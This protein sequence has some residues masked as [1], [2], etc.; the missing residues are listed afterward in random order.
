MP[1][2][3]DSRMSAS[4]DLSPPG[5][6]VPSGHR[7][8]LPTSQAFVLTPD[9]D[10]DWDGC[11]AR[12]PRMNRIDEDKMIVVRHIATSNFMSTS[13]GNYDGQAVIVKSLNLAKPRDEIV[14]ASR[15]LVTE[16]ATLTCLHHP[17]IVDFI[18]FSY[19]VERRFSCVLEYME[20]KTL[21]VLLDTP[22]A[23]AAMTWENKKLHYAIDVCRALAYMHSLTPKLIHRNMK[24]AN[25]LLTQNRQIAKLSGFGTSRFRS[26]EETMTHGV[27]NVE[28]SAPELLMAGD[29]SE[30]VDVYSL[31][32]LLVELD[33][34][35]LPLAN[36]AA[37]LHPSELSK[38]LMVGSLRPS[39]GKTCPPRIAH[40]IASCLQ[41]DPA[42]RPSSDRVLAALLKVQDEP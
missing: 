3:L 39:A 9:G 22:S 18:G 10:V 2:K 11:V 26:F 35:A 41:F 29:Y 33:T 16:I 6:S 38:R 37:K 27:G 31:G 32:V 42:L 8:S 1:G 25:V 4:G 34:C 17:N 5:K 24:A 23:A 40:V 14:S 28:W 15:A 12:L 7:I 13:L 19:S 21:R 20:N 30:K 36:E